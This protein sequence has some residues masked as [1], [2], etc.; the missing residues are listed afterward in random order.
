M[1]VLQPVTPVKQFGKSRPSVCIREWVYSIEFAGCSRCFV[2]EAAGTVT[3]DVEFSFG[4][5]FG[6]LW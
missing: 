4:I 1:N 2:P 3:R 5:V 6:L